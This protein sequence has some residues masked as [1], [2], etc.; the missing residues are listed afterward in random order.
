MKSSLKNVNF[1]DKF[2]KVIQIHYMERDSRRWALTT[3]DDTARVS[4]IHS[5]DDL[6]FPDTNLP[7]WYQRK[8][9]DEMQQDHSMIAFKIDEED[10]NFDSLQLD[11][12]LQLLQEKQVDSI[13]TRVL[14]ISYLVNNIY[15][16]DIH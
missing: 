7:W 8:D 3:D 12:D 15:I 16:T 6:F 1:T 11:L 10:N 5:G 13:V 4:I 9:L 2:L 14:S